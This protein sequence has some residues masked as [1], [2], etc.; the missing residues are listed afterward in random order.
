MNDSVEGESPVL[1]VDRDGVLGPEAPLEDQGRDR[2]FEL[3]LDRTI[4][5]AR[6]IE[7]IEADLGDLGRCCIP[8]FE[9]HVLRAEPLLEPSELDF[10]DRPDLRAVERLEHH[11]LDPSRL[12]Q[13]IEGPEAEPKRAALALASPTAWALYDVAG[14]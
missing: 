7:R 10:R 6:T 14:A 1:H 4:Q 11:D 3:L 9:L 8:D 5:W 13:V 12:G 2:L